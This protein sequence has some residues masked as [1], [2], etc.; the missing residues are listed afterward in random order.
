MQAAWTKDAARSARHLNSGM[1]AGILAGFVIGGIGGR[2]AMFVLRLT[3]D[4]SLSGRLTDDGF[5]IGRFSTDMFF[6]GLLCTAAGMAGGLF[7]MA[8]R[9]WLPAK[10]RPA[11]MALFGGAVGG[12]M[13]IRPEGIDFAEL[14]PLSLAV[15]MFVALPALYGLGMT[16]LA[17]RWIAKTEESKNYYPL[18][19]FL[20]LLGLGLGGPIGALIGVIVVAG[21]F[22]NRGIV[23]IAKM[24]RSTPVTLIGRLAFIGTIAFGLWVLGRDVASVL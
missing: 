24:W 5:E 1:W 16:W 15:A 2:L 20:P 13:I 22:M 8:I 12:A 17:E 3:S 14:D 9:G 18:V 7:Y 6:L 4:P 21:W 10:G 11:L 23:P 19:A